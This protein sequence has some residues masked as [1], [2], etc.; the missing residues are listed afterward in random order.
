[1][2]MLFLSLILVFSFSFAAPLMA[3][4]SS[5]AVNIF[6]TC[7]QG[8]AGGDP[9]VCQDA[10]KGQASK[11]DPAII[12][13]RIAIQLIAVVVGFAAVIGIIVSGIRIS[14]AH[15]DASAVATARTALIYSLVGLGIAAL[16][17]VIVL[18][19]IGFFS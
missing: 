1:M 4:L 16:A 5:S 11:V 13:I 17:Q 12:A 2:K 3:T 6:P 10:D 9:T 8:S 15:G 18:I 7:G 19:I 14:I